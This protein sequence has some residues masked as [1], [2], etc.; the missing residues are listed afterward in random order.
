MICTDQRRTL[1]EDSHGHCY[2]NRED[3]RRRRRPQKNIG[4]VVQV[5]GP[6]LDVEFE[7]EHLPEIY[8]ALTDRG[9]AAARCR[10]A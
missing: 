5:I 10:S 4:R 1:T 9:R 7:P 8:N 3:R 6:V 2:R